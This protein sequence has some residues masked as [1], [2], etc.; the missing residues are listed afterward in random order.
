MAQNDLL[1]GPVLGYEWDDEAQQSFYTV[2]VR[3]AKGAEPAWVVDGA[4]V[5]MKELR[6]LHDDSSVWRGEVALVPFDEGLGA[7]R[8]ISYSIKRGQS[9]LRNVCGDSRWS[10][11]LPGKPTPRRQ[12]RLAFCSC[13][14]FTDPKAMNGRDPLHLWQRMEA[15]HREEPFSLLLMGGDQLYCDDLARKEGSLAK[16]WAW[17]SPKDKAKAKPTHE[18]FVRGYFDH[19]LLGWARTIHNGR[20]YPHTAMVRMMACVPSVMMWDDHDIF[21]GWGSY[22][23]DE[24]KTPYYKEAFAAAREAF[25]VYQIRGAGEN[26]SL[27]DR[28]AARPRHYSQGLRFGPYHILAMDNR[29]NRGV[30]QIMS[31]LQ[32][33]QVINWLKRKS[34]ALGEGRNTLLIVSPVPVVYRRFHDW[35]SSLPG[36]HGGEDDLRDHWSHK[37]HQGERNRL[38]FHLFNVLRYAAAGGYSGEGQQGQGKFDRVTLIS[39]DVHVGALGFLE[40]TDAPAEIAQIISSAIIHPEPGAI[41]WAGLLAISRDDEHSIQG[42]SVVARMAP[43]VGASTGEDKYL[44]CRNFVWIK[45]GDDSKLWVNWECEDLRKDRPSRTE[46]GL[47]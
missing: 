4:S 5:P 9:L 36:E 28:K 14:G 11:H 7:G 31:D 8:F 17:L 33:N 32:W 3:V 35:V 19:Y 13:N 30:N 42:Q 1:L 18:E 41:A 29:T 43:P 2:I 10:F 39:G 46:F 40:R 20:E 23:A 24:K 37:N 6:K 25:E 21:D 47:R 16:L 44:R 22:Q 26:R 15:L 12:P 38:V 27:L 34:G 45:E